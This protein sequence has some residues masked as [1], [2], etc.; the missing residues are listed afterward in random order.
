MF[1]VVDEPCIGTALSNLCISARGAFKALALPYATANGS[2]GWRRG[3]NLT[4]LPLGLTNALYS[5]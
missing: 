5:C 1:Y 4:Q 2:R 3:Q